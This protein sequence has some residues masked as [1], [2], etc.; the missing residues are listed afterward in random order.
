ML[1]SEPTLCGTY[2]SNGAYNV[3]AGVY[4]YVECMSLAHLVMNVYSKS[5]YASLQIMINIPCEVS[6]TGGL[7]MPGKSMPLAGVNYISLSVI[8]G[9]S[10]VMGGLVSVGSD[11]ST[12]YETSRILLSLISINN[13]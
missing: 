9:L 13:G 7:S 1:P 5:H 3:L 4:I 10:W 11:V 6:T 2:W 8:V 12:N